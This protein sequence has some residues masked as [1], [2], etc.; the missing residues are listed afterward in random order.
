MFGNFDMK[1]DF[2]KNNKYFYFYLELVFK[3]KIDF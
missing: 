2:V 1:S 3:S